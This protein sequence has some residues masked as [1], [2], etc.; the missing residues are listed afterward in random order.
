MLSTWLKTLK[1][2]AMVRGH[3]RVSPSSFVAQQGGLTSDMFRITWKDKEPISMQDYHQAFLTCPVF[4]LELFILS[5]LQKSAW[6]QTT[7]VSHLKAVAQGNETCMGPWSVHATEGDCRTIFSAS[8]DSTPVDP[9]SLTLS[10]TRIMQ[11][12]LRGM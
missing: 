5:T 9:S 2:L 11:A 4:Q 3:R 10:V 7:R 1:C 8:S 6:Y 12:K